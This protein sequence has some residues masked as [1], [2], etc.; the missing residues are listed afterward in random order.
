MPP[1]YEVSLTSFGI[2][3][4]TKTLVF[5]T[6]FFP[7]TFLLAHFLWKFSHVLHFF[8]KS[9]SFLRSP[10]HHS[11]H[12]HFFFDAC[13]FE[14]YFCSFKDFKNIQMQKI[15]TLFFRTA[16]IFRFCFEGFRI[17]FIFAVE[18]LVSE[19][20]HLLWSSCL[21][22]CCSCIRLPRLT[23][24][25]FDGHKTN[26]TEFCGNQKD[27]REGEMTLKTVHIFVWCTWW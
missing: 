22:S 13:F 12:F 1:K 21:S 17:I 15:W 24:T 19:V 18:Q 2:P 26:L 9:L 8:L 10:W 16:F 7:S 6:V 4:R 20:P 23:I 5:P 27:E 3:M 14:F 11:S 25:W